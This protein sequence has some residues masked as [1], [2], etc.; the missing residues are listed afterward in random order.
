[1]PPNVIKEKIIVFIKVNK[2]C[3]GDDDDAKLRYI[4]QKR[5]TNKED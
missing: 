3:Q 4:L 2:P 5:Q 1:M